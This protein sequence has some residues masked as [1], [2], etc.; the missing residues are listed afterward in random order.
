MLL[1]HS[2]DFVDV[3]LNSEQILLYKDSLLKVNN[4]FP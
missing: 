4:L 3:I 1:Q 2:Y